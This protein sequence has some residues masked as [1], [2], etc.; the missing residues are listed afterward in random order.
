M[1]IQNNSLI[2]TPKLKPI[3]APASENSIIAFTRVKNETFFDEAHQLQP[4]KR[5][6]HLDSVPYSTRLSPPTSSNNHFIESLDRLYIQSQRLQRRIPYMQ[7]LEKSNDDFEELAQR[8][9]LDMYSFVEDLIN[10]LH[11]RK[12]NRREKGIYSSEFSHFEGHIL[13]CRM[14]DILTF[15]QQFNQLWFQ[16]IKAFNQDRK[17]FNSDVLSRIGTTQQGQRSQAGVTRKNFFE[18]YGIFHCIEK[19]R[20]EKESTSEHTHCVIWEKSDHPV[21][22]VDTKKRGLLFLIQDPENC[23]ISHCDILKNTMDEIK[24]ISERIEHINSNFNKNS[25]LKEVDIYNYLLEIKAISSRIDQLGVSF[26]GKDILV[27][28]YLDAVFH[29]ISLNFEDIESKPYFNKCIILYFFFIWNT[30][31]MDYLGESLSP[32]ERSNNF[33]IYKEELSRLLE[34]KFP[35]QDSILFN[36]I[37]HANHDLR[38]SLKEQ[39]ISYENLIISFFIKDHISKPKTEEILY[40]PMS[41][42]KQYYIEVIEHLH[43]LQENVS[44]NQHAFNLDDYWI[45]LK[46]IEYIWSIK[47]NSIENSNPTA[48]VRDII[49]RSK[50]LKSSTQP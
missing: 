28:N 24:E 6:R 4:N 35:F 15:I 2:N 34:K 3:C 22:A 38:N 31:I 49:N 26:A 46:I 16:H 50:T 8:F 14:T 20:F 19:W 5:K 9:E 33:N 39:F 47:L 30:T 32:N 21:L 18:E 48:I 37:S 27:A 41:I 36:M 42:R 1:K 25:R 44:A 17:Y 12:W 10:A 40:S 23:E 7:S 11:M 13:L 29:S 45:V 43:K